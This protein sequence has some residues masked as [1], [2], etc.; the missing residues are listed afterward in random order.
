M[1][2][3]PGS[4]RSAPARPR[5][6][7]APANTE[8]RGDVLHGRI[9]IEGK[10]HR[11]SLRTGDVEI[12]KSRRDEEIARLK[13]A[14]FGDGNGVS[15]EDT[16]AG[17]SESI[18]DQVGPRTAARYASSLKQLEPQLLGM[19]VV[20]SDP[21]K[22][23][24]KATVDAIVTARKAAGVC[25]A[26]I[27]RDLTA[28]SSVLIYS[29]V[30]HNPALARLEKLKEKRDPIVLP[31]LPHVRRVIQRCPGRLSALVEAALLTGCRQEELVVAELSKLDH[32]RRQ[33]SVRGKGNKIRTI[34]LSPQ[35]YELL[36]SQPVRLGCKW[37]FWHGNG[38]PYR[39]VSS[40][41]AALVRG[42]FALAYDAFHGATAKTRPNVAELVKQQDRRDWQDIGFRTFTFHHLRHYFSV[43]YLKT[44]Q[45]TIYDLQQHLGHESVKTTEIYLKFLTAE[46]KRTAMYGAAP[47]A[48]AAEQRGA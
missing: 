4:G 30:E 5:R 8:W 33:L 26:T 9:R 7:K 14:V 35:A 21:A 37:L 16:F 25:I 44:G 11:W 6:A 40:R 12:A 2:R 3:D 22:V 39:N 45:G 43:E 1:P 48:A 46:E 27:R 41:F 15:Y 38:Q 18:A 31:Q 36:R 32:A 10:L 42:E 23:I 29:E 24:G 28:L 47:A 13:A 19:F 20:H 17:W 34:D